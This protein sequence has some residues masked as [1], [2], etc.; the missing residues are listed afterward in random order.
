MGCG[1][2]ARRHVLSMKELQERGR[3]DFV[4]TAVC[5]ANEANALEKADMFEELS[6]CAPRSIPSPNVNHQA[7]VDA[8][9][10]CLPHG[11]H[12]SI[13]VDCMEGGLDVLCEK[14]LG[15]TIKACRQMIDAAERTGKVLSTAAP[16]RRQPG[17]RVAHWIFNESKLIGEPQS[18]FHTYRRP[19]AV[20]TTS[21]EP[22]PDRVRWRQDKL[23]SGG[24]P[25][26]DSGFHYC[27]SI[28]YFFG[29]VDKVYAE[30]RS[31]KTGVTLPFTEAP[32]DTVMVTFTFKSGVVGNWAWSL[33]A[34]GE[35][36]YNVTFYG[37]EG[38]LRD[39][40]A[41]RFSI[42][43]LFERRPEQNETALLT[44]K[45]GTTYS[46]VELEAMHRKTLNDQTRELL[47]PGGTTDGFSIEI[48][49]FLEILR[50]NI[51]K[52]EIDGWEGLR[53]LAIGDAIYESALTGDV[54]QVDEVVSG[55]RAGFQAPID[56]HWGL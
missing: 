54:I 36:A 51:D 16:H 17:Q 30:L 6:V 21:N 8:V 55:A 31:L 47:Y 22:V 19:P 3:G 12:H 18:F 10:M 49:E 13:A 24:G 39:T 4:V 28:R 50:G 26:L 1:G 15:I 52:P 14:P 23:M 11:L 9:D 25:V 53:S 46:M 38:S 41:G 29:E 44:Q 40:T 27:D 32:E 43:H 35:E 37:S 2:I 48:W 20:P 56:E 33:A 34:P 45:D 7:G 5:D 42:F